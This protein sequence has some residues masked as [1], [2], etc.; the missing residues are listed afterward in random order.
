MSMAK[1]ID[2]CEGRILPK[3][4]F[5][6]LPIILGNLFQQAYN[7]VDTLIVGRVLGPDSLAS[8]GSAYA[9][10]TFINSLLIGLS[11]GSGALFS[12]NWGKGEKAELRKDIYN[13]FILFSILAIILTTICYVFLNQIL[14][15]LRT[16]KELLIEEKEYLKIIFLGIFFV[17]LYN[18][19]SYIL[20]SK[21]DSKTPLYFLILSALI[22][23]AL[24]LF[25]IIKLKR[26]VKGAGEATVIAEAFSALGIITFFFIRNKNLL[27]LKEERIIEVN[28]LKNIL[29][30]SFLTSIQ[31][32][33]MNFGILMIQ[34]LVNS[35]GSI[36]MAAFAASVK[37][38]TLSYT[39][40]QEFGN[41]YSIFISQ[42]LGANKKDR[43]KKGTKEAFVLTSFVAIIL[44]IVIYTFSSNLMELFVNKDEIEVIKIGVE[45][46]HIEGV[47]YCG[48][49]LLFALYGYYR[50]IGRPEY[51]IVLTVISLGLRVLLAYC[52]SPYLG[53]KAI[54]WAIVIGW[55]VADITG[56]VLLKF[57][58]VKEGESL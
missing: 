2:L 45:Y 31:Q 26:G 16:P 17:F 13:S 34:S 12:Y 10:M 50:G 44:S 55:I 8:V 41:A 39:P 19:V 48:I 25:F 24:D 42:N 56:L 37:I 9:L 4:V 7:L 30:Y 14:V 22:N 29:R 36:T 53:R 49:A 23:I 32:S 47:F 40:S 27:P 20:R 57:I 51:S 21:G 58:K 43:V 11:M 28:R 46:L 33:V 6:S 35:F 5:F 54:W 1:E 15:L 18:Y 3:I 52:L 38:D